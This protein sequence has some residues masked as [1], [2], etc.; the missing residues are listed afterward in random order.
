MDGHFDKACEVLPKRPQDPVVLA[1]A[2]LIKAACGDLRGGLA[3]YEESAA[4][5][6]QD[7]DHVLAE[8]IDAGRAFAYL[9]AGE[10]VPEALIRS[11]VADNPKLALVA[12]AIEREMSA[13]T[14]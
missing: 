11:D 10:S 14:L 7:G 12:A 6:R 3:D 9:L 2:G 5:T 4:L 1:T 8:V 13:R